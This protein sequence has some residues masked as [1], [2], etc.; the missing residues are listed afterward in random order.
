MA[1]G[2]VRTDN[3]AGIYDGSKIVSIKF[4]NGTAD[5]EIDNG[6]VVALDAY[7]GQDVYKAVKP[8][9]EQKLGKL[10]LVA[11]VELFKDREKPLDQWVNEAGVPC[12]AYVLQQGDVF[13]VTADVISGTPDATTNK[14]VDIDAATTF[15]AGPVASSGKANFAELIA[16]ETA[17]AYT[18]YVYRVL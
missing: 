16:I 14:Y 1:H 5:A 3:L 6:S 13:S 9:A 10:A 8:T 12:R 2:V 17:G 11:G 4:N 7:L 15:K 18:Y